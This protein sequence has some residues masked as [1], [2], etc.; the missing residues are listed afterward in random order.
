MQGS[1]ETPV[2]PALRRLM[3]A[4][5]QW[6]AA[7]DCARIAALAEAHNTAARG[8]YASLGMQVCASY[9]YRALEDRP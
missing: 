5:A 2:A 4:A 6:A 8:L 9:H 1:V 3:A 7:H